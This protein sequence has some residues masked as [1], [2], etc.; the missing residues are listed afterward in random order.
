VANFLWRQGNY[1]QPTS[2]ALGPLV[3]S[4][5]SMAILALSGYLGGKLAYHYGVRVAEETKQAE[6][7]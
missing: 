3:L 2:V 7:F 6:G 5:V 1:G 4:A